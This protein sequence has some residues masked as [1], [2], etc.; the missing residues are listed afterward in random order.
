MLRLL[1]SRSN[2]V[3]SRCRRR[4]YTHGVWGGQPS[5]S[6][7]MTG[8]AVFT[9]SYAVIPREVQR[10]IVASSLPGW[11]KTRLWILARPM[12]G[13]AETFSQYV[14]ECEAGGGSEKP[15]P[16]NEAEGVIF[17]LEGKMTLTVRGPGRP[18]KDYELTAGSYA[19]LHWSSWS[20]SALEKSKFTWIRKKYEPA[21]GVDRPD[22]F[23]THERSVEAMDMPGAEGKWRT[24]RFVDPQDMA[25]D[26]H[27]NI[28]SFDPGA[29][30]PFKETH[31]MEH[32]L[33]VLQGKAVYH[34]NT[35]WVEVQQGD[36]IWLRAFCP[37]ACYASGPD[38]F[39]Y[40][41]YKD[42]N[43]HPKLDL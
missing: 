28:V 17:C 42:V 11:E 9:N 8:R 18:R 41:L 25:H 7:L 34:L 40:L 3:V 12:T 37:Q 24:Q 30:I 29:V 32:G 20:L 33:L 19:Y 4:A 15:E 31:V 36:F 16:N 21:K 10:D 26:M 23:V 43:R 39:K 38:T 13:F 14:V 1:T 22:T 6:E 27:V 5:Q 2:L 35:D